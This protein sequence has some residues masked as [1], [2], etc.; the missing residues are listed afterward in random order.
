MR[1]PH[2]FTREEA[3]RCQGDALVVDGQ[4][5]LQIADPLLGVLQPF[6]GVGRDRLQVGDFM[7]QRIEVFGGQCAFFFLAAEGRFS[8][9]LRLVSGSF[10]LADPL[11][12]RLDGR[13]AALNLL[14]ELLDLLLLRSDG[15]LQFLH[16]RRRGA[17]SKS[18]RRHQ[19]EGQS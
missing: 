5:A 8:R 18:A 2:C 6:D 9:R 16:T 12:Q 19:Q 14:L 17:L 1:T 3:T 10:R 4:R 15:V 13:V 11:F 7:L